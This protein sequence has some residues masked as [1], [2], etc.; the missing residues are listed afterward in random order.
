MQR[1]GYFGNGEGHTP[2]AK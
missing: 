1:L 2:G